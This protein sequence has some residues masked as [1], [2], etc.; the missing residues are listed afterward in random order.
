MLLTLGLGG[1]AAVVACV[2]DEQGI[3]SGEPG[4]DASTGGDSLASSDGNVSGDGDVGGDGSS[5]T[6]SGV[7]AGP[8]LKPTDPVAIAAGVNHAC[9]LRADHR[10]YCWGD[11]ASAELG[12]NAGAVGASAT[13]IVVTFA[14]GVTPVNLF[15]GPAFT[16]IIDSAGGVWCWGSNLNG[17]LGI[18]DPSN[19]SFAAPQR[20][21]TASGNI[22]AAVP[23]SGA[24][25][26]DS[27]HGGI[28][29]AADGNVMGWGFDGIGAY[30][31]NKRY[32]DVPPASA[33]NTPFLSVATGGQHSVA[34]V[35]HASKIALAAWGLNS[36]GELGVL[37]SGGSFTLPVYPS[38]P[39]NGTVALVAA[40]GTHTCAVDTTG[41]LSCW[42]RNGD[43][44]IGAS[45]TGTSPGLLPVANPDFQSDRVKALALGTNNTCVIIESGDVYCFGKNDKGE[46][47]TTA[48]GS[49]ATR[50]QIPLISHDAVAI[51]A[52]DEF[53]CAIRQAL[54]S[55]NRSVWCWGFNGSQQLGVADAGMAF[56]PTPVKIPLPE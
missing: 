4:D 27:N 48:G 32:A 24:A 21:V 17:G 43:H 50:Q 22:V 6:D 12:P 3:S 46:L 10:V 39:N 56:S 18:N 33:G 8:P 15:A 25:S 11:N 2:G 55:G 23:G 7:D 19:A 37:D 41:L 20:M 26:H 54:L 40:G 14:S 51:A 52:G 13:P 45:G 5:T 38:L 49:N 31:T 16:C 47:G 42:G 34:I 53:Y 9:A 36:V 35:T 30:G 44:E 1:A 29:V 28:L